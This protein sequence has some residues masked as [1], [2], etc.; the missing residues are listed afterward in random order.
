LVFAL[1]AF[2]L[3]FESLLTPVRPGLVRVDFSHAPTLLPLQPDPTQSMLVMNSFPASILLSPAWVSHFGCRSL[4]RA[5]HQ[6]SV[7]VSQGV[8][9]SCFPAGF[10]VLTRGLPFRP[11][12]FPLLTVCEAQVLQCLLS[13]CLRNEAC[14]NLLS[15]RSMLPSQSGHRRI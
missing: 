7:P 9:H 3:L 13:G 6:I 12:V 2:I 10:M 1:R 4:C 15:S 11:L 5:R 14:L 8:A